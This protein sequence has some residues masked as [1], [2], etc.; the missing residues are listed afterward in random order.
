[1]ATVFVDFT[2]E[3]QSSIVLFCGQSYS[4]QM[5]FI[6]KCFLFTVGSVCRVKRFTTGSG[7]SFKDVRK[8][9]TIPDQ[10]ALLRL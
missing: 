10:V 3:E 7:N 9:Q 6:K 1:M 2:T 5:I 8:S 4:M